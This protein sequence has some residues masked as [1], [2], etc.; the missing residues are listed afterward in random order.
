MKSV[1]I[2]VKR[3]PTK[4][5]AKGSPYLSNALEKRHRN[6]IIKFCVGETKNEL[7]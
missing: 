1:N 5:T 2:I 4:L 7:K 6:E 3:D